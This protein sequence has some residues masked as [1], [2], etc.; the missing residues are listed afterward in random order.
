MEKIQEIG[1]GRVVLAHSIR[2][3][4]ARTPNI[5]PRMK[6]PP[7]KMLTRAVGKITKADST[8]YF[9]KIIT[10]AMSS[11]TPRITPRM[12][13]T[14]P[15]EAFQGIIVFHHAAKLGEVSAS[16]LAIISPDAK[17]TSTLEIHENRVSNGGF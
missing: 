6:P 4:P 10:T 3:I 5:A 7:M 16:P 8:L 14:D 12:M 13:L 2:S 17:T 9:R 1:H 15:S 11:T